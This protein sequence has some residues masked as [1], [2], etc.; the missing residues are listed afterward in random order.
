MDN[1]SPAPGFLS[2]IVVAELGHRTAA[3][4]CGSLLSMLGAEV[5]VADLPGP[6]DFP[7]KWANRAVTIAGKTC[8]S[9]TSAGDPQ[10]RHL[11][12]RADIVLLSSDV[13][14]IPLP[15]NP[16]RITCDFT[17]FG[18]DG[19]L[20]GQALPDGLVQ[21]WSGV[22]DTTGSRDGPPV[23]TGAPFV[24]MEAGAYGAAAILAAL[25]ERDTSGLG[26]SV[27]IALYDVGVN[28]L[29]TFVPL[30]IA[31]LQATRNG[32]RHPSMTPWNSFRA[33]DGK[34]VLICAPTD[35]MWR[36]LCDEMGRPDLALDPRFATTSARLANVAAIDAE[37]AAWVGSVTS[38]EAIDRVNRRGIPGS[39][40]L[41]IEDLAQESNIRHR[42]MMRHEASAIVPGTLFR[43]RGPDGV[44]TPKRPRRPATGGPLAG[45][46]IVEI[47][48]NTVGPLAGRQL[49][50]L[51]ADV[52]KI[53]PP[54]GDTN[55]YNA[56]LR[57]DGA[58]YVF[59]LSNTDK[60]GFVLDLKTEDGRDR[61][62]RIL[63]TSDALIENL[64]P[65][66]LQKLGLGP[67]DV[68]RRLPHLVYCS[69]NGFGFDTVYPGRPA[70]D[71]VIQAMSGAMDVTR[72][73]GMP[74]KA[75]ISIS[76]QLGGQTG[77]VAVLAG[78]RAAR[79]TG[80][81]ATFDL[82]MQDATLWAT[83][84]VWP[85]AEDRAGVGTVS[86]ADG[87]VLVSGDA[88]HDIGALT[89]DAAVRYLE[90]QGIAAAPVLTVA[91]VL[92]HPQTVA[93][94][95]FTTVPTPDG[96]SFPALGCP[97]RLS[98]TPARTRM[99]MAALGFPYPDPDDE[100]PR[101]R[102]GGRT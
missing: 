36:K 69:V 52:I 45:L 1:T 65:G 91:E 79:H 17:A 82:A 57:D 56:P 3:S 53:E 8:L 62:F 86:V 32:N 42:G 88:Q 55:R 66:A 76:D 46:R 40:I 58:S 44:R 101:L 63:E 35:E 23:P 18:S 95:L 48:M 71:T 78:L 9:A 54:T 24:S 77:L 20:A 11:I 90:G 51:G 81:G 64:K 29:L 7:R 5:V 68:R 31:G 6:G 25:I 75:G 10:V 60:R 39:S 92:Q 50:A 22:A 97:M 12:D 2:G 73:A 61:L 19:P 102:S 15:Q 67:E 84:M 49:G 94:D 34:W 89:R 100:A 30:V 43:S 85:A 83:S 38:D 26:Q 72:S 70:L 27:D 96:D 28:A 4:A 21:G 99:T 87:H 47:G 37:I 14:A 74:T 33:R 93:R 98:R 41:A 80:R 13:E 16:T 59:M